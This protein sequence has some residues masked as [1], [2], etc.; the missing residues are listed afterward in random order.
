M[1]LRLIL[2]SLIVGLISLFLAA[3]PASARIVDKEAYQAWGTSQLTVKEPEAFVMTTT[4][5]FRGGPK[6]LFK[7]TLNK[8]QSSEMTLKGKGYNLTMRCFPSAESSSHDDC[9]LKTG[10][11]TWKNATNNDASA[12]GTLIGT[13]VPSVETN[14]DTIYDIRDGYA[15]V[16]SDSPDEGSN[17][18]MHSVN[19]VTITGDTVTSVEK[20]I[21]YNTPF[22]STSTMVLL[23]HP[24]SLPRPKV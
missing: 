2:L 7:R 12:F 5:S 4:Y 1:R 3:S 16:T 22:A 19:R 9:Y 18:G 23:P 17:N 10:K 20:G 11:S 8:D 13:R 15:I 6:A 24:V 21:F 14:P